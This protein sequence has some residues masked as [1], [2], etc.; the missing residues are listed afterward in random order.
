MEQLINVIESCFKQNDWPYERFEEDETALQFE[1]SGKNAYFKGYVYTEESLR[2][3]VILIFVPNLIPENKRI[4]VAEYFNRANYGLSVGNFELD[5]DDGE[6]RYRVAVD[7][8]GGEMS[9]TM[10]ENMVGMGFVLT[11]RYYPG[12][13]ALLYSDATP[14]EAIAAVEG[15]ADVEEDEEEEEEDED[16]GEKE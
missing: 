14:A 8:E 4:A 15:S 5:M 3:V 7:I 16:E 12:I 6:A 13:M 1:I 11:D 2:H 10:V 9:T